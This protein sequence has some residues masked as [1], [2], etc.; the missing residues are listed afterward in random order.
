MATWGDFAQQNPELADAGE[1]LLTQFGV[2][3]AFLAMVRKDGVRGS[4][5][6]VPFSPAEVSTFSFRRCLRRNGTF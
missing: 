2:G 3:L 6:S 4:I 1:K 5:R